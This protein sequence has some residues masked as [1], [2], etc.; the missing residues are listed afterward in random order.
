MTQAATKATS[1]EYGRSYQDRQAQKYRGRATNHWKARIDLFNDLVDRVALPRLGGREAGPIMAV[2]IGCSVGTFAIEAA[3]RGFQSVGLDMDPEALVAAR[4]LASEEGV[5]PEFVC[6]D[7]SA[8]AAGAGSIDLA[9]AFDLF[10]HLHDDE[11]GSLL[12]SIRS[13]LSPRG[14]LVYH[15]FPTEFDYLF[16]ED[17]GRLAAPLEAHAHQPPD[18]FERTTRALA[19][20]LDA[21]RLERGLPTQREAIAREPHCNPLTVTRLEAMLRRAG[22]RSLE[23][24]TAQLY[25]FFPEQMARFAG[26][27]IADR[28]LFGVA[29]PA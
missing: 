8:W 28:N 4:G 21:E 25:P 2:D 1:A 18:Q 13:A 15:T 14:S 9:I 6:A 7:V 20:R 19:L 24:R 5:S 27:P 12:R 23:I 3:R 22:F 11:L 10:E 26:Q 17:G 29:I 16:F